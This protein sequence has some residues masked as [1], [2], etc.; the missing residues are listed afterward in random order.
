MSFTWTEDLV[1]IDSEDLNEIKTN[2]DSITTYLGIAPFLWSELPVADGGPIQSA[3]VQEL[4]SATDYIDDNKCLA[5]YATHDDGYD[6][7]Y[8]SGILNNDHGTYNSGVDSPVDT[9][10][11]VGYDSSYMSG[12][13]S[14]YHGAY[15]YDVNSPVDSAD[16]TGYDS[17]FNSGVLNDLH[18]TYKS[19]VKSS[20]YSQYCIAG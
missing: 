6:A 20:V 2:I 15:Y 5:D 11:D 12:V 1:T 4:R 17:D 8:N 19:G 3:D 14:N 10:A 9:A 18:G 7:T 16:N 13:L